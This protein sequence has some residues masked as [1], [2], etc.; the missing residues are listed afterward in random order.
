MH[1][2]A[3]FLLAAT[4]LHL[5]AIPGVAAVAP[6]WV[7]SGWVSA[8]QITPYEIDVDVDSA[9]LPTAPEQDAPRFRDRPPSQTAPHHPT[10][11][12]RRPDEQPLALRPT[13]TSEPRVDP[14]DL[15]LAN[16]DAEGATDEYLRPPT[17]EELYGPPGRPGIGPGGE[18]WRQP[19]VIPD[20]P[21]TALPAPTK[22]PERQYDRQ[23]ATKVLQ[24]GVRSKDRKLGLD[25][26]GRGPIRS[27][28]VSAVYSSD[29]PYTCSAGFSLTVNRSGKVTDVT[30]IGFSG[31]S[32]AT[33][34]T[35]TKTARG[36]LAGATLPMK[37]GF[38]KGAVVGVKVSSQVRT[39]AGG[40]SR[41]GLTINFDPSDIGAKATRLVSAFVNPQPIQ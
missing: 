17:A 15:L 28:F 2:D 21:S 29:A 20:A 37:S 7:P 25:F 36:A 34:K 10:S 33:W 38:A 32:A 40:T 19:G 14:D 41:E 26:P 30:L 24:D 6:R 4:A 11:T 23:A 1:A 27:A 35:V 12:S 16:P 13:N 22:A 5:I 31:G 8:R 3:K 9:L 39:P 18:V